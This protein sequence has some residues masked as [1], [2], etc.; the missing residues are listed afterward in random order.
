MESFKRLTTAPQKWAT[1]TLSDHIPVLMA[2]LKLKADDIAAIMSFA[3]VSDSLTL[4]NVS[5]LYRYS[6]LAKILHIRVPLLKDVIALFGNPFKESLRIYGV[7][8]NEARWAAVQA[9]DVTLDHIR[10]RYITW[11]KPL[12]T[13][14]IVGGFTCPPGIFGNFGEV[15]KPG[16]AVF[17]ASPALRAGLGQVTTATGAVVGATGTQQDPCGQMREAVRAMVPAPAAAT[18]G[19]DAIKDAILALPLID[20]RIGTFVG[21][22]VRPRRPEGRFDAV[23]SGFGPGQKANWQLDG[24]ELQGTSGQ[25]DLGG[26]AVAH[27][28]I[29]GTTLLL[30]IDA[31][32]PV[33]MLL[34][35]TIVDEAAHAASAQRCVHYEPRCTGRGRLT[36]T[37]SDYRTAWL[38]NYGVVEVP[39]PAPVIL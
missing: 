2:A 30:T 22:I 23:T 3:P 11:E 34:S 1:A 25:Q 28:Q 32:A 37:W 35:V 39:T 36:P 9:V 18:K 7:R 27:Y 5:I 13:V 12:A 16:S 6:L 17:V 26:G 4:P 8:T 14:Q 33:E 24:N 21:P 10:F 20:R 31:N 19:S 29:T 15:A 38:T